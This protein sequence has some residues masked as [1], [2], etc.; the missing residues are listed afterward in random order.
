MPLN[1]A[2]R[3]IVVCVT[4]ILKTHQKGVCQAC[5]CTPSLC[6][7]L[8]RRAYD[9]H[10]SGQLAALY[11][12][13]PPASLCLHSSRQD[14]ACVSDSANHTLHCNQHHSDCQGTAYAAVIS[15]TLAIMSDKTTIVLFSPIDV[16]M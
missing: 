3:F 8:N 9:L 10:K 4:G 7:H 15:H 5:D 6:A 13:S 12:F 1:V 14:T 11:L 16:S 2:V